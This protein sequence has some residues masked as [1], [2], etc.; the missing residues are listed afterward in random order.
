MIQLTDKEEE[1]ANAFYSDYIKYDGNI[2]NTRWNALGRLRESL[3]I[4]I[5]R[6]T[7]ITNY[8]EQNPHD[9]VPQKSEKEEDW[10]LIREYLNSKNYDNDVYQKQ[11]DTWLETYD[12]TEEEQMLCYYYK[13][14]G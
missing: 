8:I 14:I 13:A 11:I 2:P 3:G 10:D 4:T 5:G 7:R 1:F 6:G 12:I 9:F